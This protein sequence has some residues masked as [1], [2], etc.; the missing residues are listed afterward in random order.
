MPAF[1][2]SRIWPSRLTCHGEYP[3]EAQL[4]TN[5]ALPTANGY[6]DFRCPWKPSAICVLGEAEKNQIVFTSAS[7]ALPNCVAA[8][9]FS[10]SA[11]RQPS[12]GQ[13]GWPGGW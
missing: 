5:N 11:A 4:V 7:A 6:P 9:L 2:N 10:F 3:S 8:S 13:R 12:Y 1:R